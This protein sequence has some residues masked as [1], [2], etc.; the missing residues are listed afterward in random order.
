MINTSN[1]SEQVNNQL[2]IND[3]KQYEMGEKL[4]EGTFGK[5]ILAT[6]KITKEKVAI[7]ILDKLRI[8]RK[9]DQERINREI[10]ILK[11][12]KHYNIIKLLTNFENES[13]IYIIQ[14]YIPGYELFEYLQNNKRL[15]EREA[16]LFY[17]QIISGIEYLHK[18]GIAHRDLKP[19]NILLSYSKVLKII[20]FGLSILYSKNELL[21]TQCGSPCYAPPEMIGG[22]SYKGISADIWSSGIIL[23]MMLTGH[24]PFNELTNKKLY[25]KILNGKYTIPKDLSEEAKNLIKKI[26]EVNPKKRITIEQIKQ[27]PWFNMINR[28]FNMHE[29]IDMK[30]TVI[31]IDEEII[32]QMNKIGFNKMQ[33]RDNI[34]RNLHNNISTTYYLLLG[35]K[36]REN[37]ESIADLFSYSFERYMDDKINDISNYNND[38]IN[39]L[40][41]R[42]S[43]KG[44]LENLPD[45]ENNEK[46]INKESHNKDNIK[47]INRNENKNKNNLIN[48]RNEKH[49][50]TYSTNKNKT[51]DDNHKNENDIDIKKLNEEINNDNQLS[52][53]ER[54]NHNIQKKNNNPI[55]QTS[56]PV[57]NIKIIKKNKK[58]EKIHSLNKKKFNH[59][60]SNRIIFN[61]NDNNYV[62]S[63]P[64]IKK[65]SNIISLNIIH[66][67][68]RN[69]STMKSKDTEKTK[70]SII[71]EIKKIYKNKNKSLDNTNK[72]NSISNIFSDKPNNN[73]NKKLNLF[74][75]LSGDFYTKRKEIKKRN[76][77][78][79]VNENNNSILKNCSIHNIFNNKEYNNNNN[80]NDIHIKKKNIKKYGT[81]N[82]GN[83][84]K[85]ENYTTKRKSNS[86]KTMNKVISLNL[87]KKLTNK[88]YLTKNIKKPN[89]ICSVNKNKSTKN[90]NNKN[91]ILNYINNNSVSSPINKDISVKEQP[92]YY[93]K[94]ENLK[95][96]KSATINAKHENEEN[97]K[98]VKNKKEKR[99]IVKEDNNCEPRDLSMIFFVKKQKIVSLLKNYFGENNIKIKK[100]NV[101]NR[102]FFCSKNE[103]I[104]FEILIEKNEN[105]NYNYIRIKIIKGEKKFFI[106]LFKY[107]NLLIH[108]Y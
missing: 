24:L 27:H 18:L 69:K 20:D 4:G 103:S 49:K 71:H 61:F 68:Q 40:K 53:S 94:V 96:K 33:V 78:Y 34:L 101:N 108:Y 86:V 99:I 95:L 7:K 48:E 70:Y 63:E 45:F 80:N 13:K 82:E 46:R 60:L 12:V 73:N 30:K 26:L 90:I 58:D 76:K 39:V 42:I 11:K 22:K 105:Y 102:K 52:L 29:G 36:I 9:E 59:S 1:I 74:T 54:N 8:N 10:E 81:K 25:N 44:K 41:E 5:V 83:N 100:M 28:I 47:V 98:I 84:N 66:H 107:I 32:E 31:P 6:H 72:N 65:P 77:K 56:S 19:E 64:N 62:D 14:E 57:N 93:I 88:I 55:K 16:C 17:Q 35:K 92:N 87:N 97:K 104:L 91:I 43:S 106:D 21:R 38:I 89:I 23:F 37:R 2:F 79:H 85:N 50:K 15:S 51:K 3:I 75:F 67:Q